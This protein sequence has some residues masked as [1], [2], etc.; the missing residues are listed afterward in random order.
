MFTKNSN[1]KIRR[2]MCE[3]LISILVVLVEVLK[4]LRLL[5][6]KN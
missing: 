6:K 5:M 4:R 3:K 2:E 1:V